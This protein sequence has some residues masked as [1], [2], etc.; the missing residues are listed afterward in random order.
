MLD[1]NFAD[2]LFMLYSIKNRF[3]A[4]VL[5]CVALP[6]FATP[7]VMSQSSARNTVELNGWWE[8]Q[9]E[10][11]RSAVNVPSAIPLSGTVTRW[12]R[13]FNLALTARP[14]VA[15]IEFAGI[16]NSA[17]VRLNGV[18]VGTLRALTST[19]LDVRDALVL[20]G[21]NRIELDIDDRLTETSVPGGPT[22]LFTSTF[23]A[24]AYQLPIP[25]ESR[26]GIV[27]DVKLVWSNRPI[28][29]DVF[30]TPL[31]SADL[32]NVDVRVRVRVL[33]ASP[34]VV[35]AWVGLTSGPVSLANCV[36]LESAADELSCQF[37]VAN[38]ALWSPEQPKLHELFVTLFDG[39]QPSDAV[40]DR[41]GFRRIEARGNQIFLNNRRLFLRGISRHDLYGDAG[42]V[43]NAE[44][45]E[46]DLRHIKKLGANYVRAIHYP[47]DERVA[48]R[49][50]EI[51]LLL[52]QEIPAWAELQTPAVADAAK[53]M[54]RSMVE[55]DYNRP[56]VI[57][58]F[59]GST[60]NTNSTSYFSSGTS[61]VKALDPTRLVSFV[62]DSPV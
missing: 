30:A 22:S 12:S 36:A 28:V 42:F 4:L 60:N 56:S 38:P 45:I 14:A 5:A 8:I 1:L 61:M 51:G 9:G 10:G 33:G 35:A 18:Q 20:N 40:Y 2:T 24:M 17:V 58:W 37:S 48:R 41:I 19:R 54:V 29:T 52:S 50:D 62:F 53:S 34:K 27:R 31:L 46:A 3:L 47:P 57:F 13:T 21:I 39:P 26:P 55:R 7:Y 25:W 6:C 43:A 59:L 49:A 23:G 15:L 44:M 16:A 11:F 32:K